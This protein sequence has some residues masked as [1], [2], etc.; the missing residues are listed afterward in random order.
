MVQRRNRL[1]WS[2]QVVILAECQQRGITGGR[3]DVQGIGLWAMKRLKLWQPPSYHSIL[4]VIRSE[5]QIIPNSA[6]IRSHLKND[7][8]A[9]NQDIETNLVNRVRHLKEQ[10]VC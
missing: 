7:V 5:D 1:S 9:Y 3:E 4:K 2:Q 6:S 8:Y 10:G